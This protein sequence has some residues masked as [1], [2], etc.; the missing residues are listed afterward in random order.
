MVEI[1]DILGI[2]IFQLQVDVRL[3]TLIYIPCIISD[4]LYEIIAVLKL[5]QCCREFILRAESLL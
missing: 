4:E 1:I 3:I 5:N 2:H